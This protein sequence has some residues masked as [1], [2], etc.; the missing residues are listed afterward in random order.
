MFILPNKT[1]VILEVIDDVPIFREDKIN[2][3]LMSD[4][5][6]A[7]NI[8]APDSN[9]DPGAKITGSA[10]GVEPAIS[11]AEVMEIVDS[12]RQNAPAINADWSSGH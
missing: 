10:Q 12:I 8:I 5:T 6:V 1:A 4:I 2:I 3:L 11:I 7:P 9:A